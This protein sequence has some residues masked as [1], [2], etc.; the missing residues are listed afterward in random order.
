MKLFLMIVLFMSVCNVVKAKNIL[1][2]MQKKPNIPF[3]YNPIRLSKEEENRL[4]LV[5]NSKKISLKNPGFLFDIETRKKYLK[6]EKLGKIC[7]HR[8]EIFDYSENITPYKYLKDPKE[9]RKSAYSEILIHKI[10]MGSSHFFGSND[11]A[12]S[13]GDDAGEHTLRLL[14]A[15]AKQDYPSMDQKKRYGHTVGSASQFF[16]ASAWAIQLL[17]NHPKLTEE[18]KTRIDN[19]LKNKILGKHI[20]FKKSSRWFDVHDGVR[21]EPIKTT[22]SGISNINCCTPMGFESTRLQVDNALMAGSILYNDIDGFK[23]SL[24]GFIDVVDTMRVDGSLPYQT[25]RGNAAIWYQNLGI[26]VLIAAAEMAKYQGIDLYSFKS[27][28]GSTIHDAITFLLNSIENPDIIYK[29]A[30]RNINPW[31]KGNGVTDPFDYKFQL[32]AGKIFKWQ[33]GAHKA[34]FLSWYEIY[35]YRFP[36]HPNLKKLYKLA[37]NAKNRV[38]N[39]IYP[40]IIPPSPLYNDYSGMS[41]TCLYFN[42]K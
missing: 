10:I 28:S 12:I 39:I 42:R 38:F 8:Y 35:N 27:K 5:S 9:L 21:Q 7:R 31:R 3:G 16:H 29:Y 26:N 37:V 4:R 15:Y 25:S 33:R 32:G 2:S 6:K 22:I 30:S 24:K 17:E 13:R 23:S 1:T 14:E 20:K 34:S 18:R 19:W 36:D 11:K 41:T 40:S